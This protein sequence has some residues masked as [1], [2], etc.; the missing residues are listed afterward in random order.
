MKYIRMQFCWPEDCVLVMDYYCKW[1]KP[2]L[3]LRNGS[4][5][6]LHQRNNIK[7]YTKGGSDKYIQHCL[8]G[9][10]TCQYYSACQACVEHYMW[11][12]AP[13]FG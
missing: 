1:Y 10:A 12:P 6:G 3:M 7:A 2:M 4:I 11:K 5:T 8:K 9:G 13:I